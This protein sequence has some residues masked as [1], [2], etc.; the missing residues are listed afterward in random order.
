MWVFAMRP[1]V[2]SAGN[3]AAYFLKASKG[4]GFSPESAKMECVP[5]L[6]PYSAGEKQVTGLTC[7]QGGTHWES[8][9]QCGSRNGNYHSAEVQG[10]PR[11]M[12]KKE[13]PKRFVQ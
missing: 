2:S 6:V 12:V 5:S 13:P 7:T 10:I 8:P 4:G 1:S 11:T 9:P 3:M